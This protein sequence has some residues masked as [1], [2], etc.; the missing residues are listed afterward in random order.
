[1]E[2]IFLTI[3][4]ENISLRLANNNNNTDA[5][6]VRSHSNQN[7]NRQMDIK[8]IINDNNQ[9]LVYPNP[10]NGNFIIETKVN[11]LCI[12]YDVNGN[13]VFTQKISGK[14]T[15]DVSSLIDGVYNINL[16]NDKS[17]INKRLVIVK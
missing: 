14:I 16:I 15:F 2:L 5:A 7:N 6:K 13:E 17:T 10:T 8:Q 4:I 3:K 12:I 11:S 1:M 9:V